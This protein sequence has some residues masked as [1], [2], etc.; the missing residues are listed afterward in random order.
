MKT[1]N[2]NIGA[3][4]AVTLVSGFSSAVAVDTV[5]VSEKAAAVGMLPHQKRGEILEEKERNPFAAKVEF[6]ENSSANTNTEESAI[7]A[8][9]SELREIS[10]GISHGE[11]GYSA[12]VGG[13]ILKTGKIVDQLIPNQTDK[14]KVIKV[15]EKSVEIS[16]LNEEGAE[17]PRKHVLELDMRPLVGQILPGT[18]GGKLELIDPRGG[19]SPK[20]FNAGETNEFFVE[21]APAIT[22]E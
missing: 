22:P 6:V 11:D 14:L 4:I 2:R 17:E 3:L 7:R 15:T 8:K 10:M 5:Q 20:S 13:L 9:L 18:T 12:Q 21:G 16:W 19:P 1:K